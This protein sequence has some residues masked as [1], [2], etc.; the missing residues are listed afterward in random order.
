M[1]GDRQMS[2]AEKSRENSAP[3]IAGSSLLDVPSV[4][5]VPSRPPNISHV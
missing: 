2:P 4:D 3:V 5:S 1:Q